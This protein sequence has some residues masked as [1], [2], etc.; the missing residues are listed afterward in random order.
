[1][2]LTNNGIQIKWNCYYEQIMVVTTSFR[3]KCLSN[4]LLETFSPNHA[5]FY[6]FI[7]RL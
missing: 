4:V 2:H 6:D 3:L 5:S 7:N 1:M